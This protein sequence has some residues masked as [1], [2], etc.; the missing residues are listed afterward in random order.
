ML[1]QAQPIL[2]WT[3]RQTH[4]QGQTKAASDLLR[5]LFSAGALRQ[6]RVRFY[7]PGK[8]PGVRQAL[9]IDLDESRGAQSELDGFR[10]LWLIEQ[11]NGQVSL[12][13]SDKPPTYQSIGGTVIREQ[14]ALH[15]GSTLYG[16][17]SM[18]G[19]R[20]VRSR[21]WASHQIR[22][23][24]EAFALLRGI[25]Q[26]VLASGVE[27]FLANLNAVAL[28][29]VRTEYC[30][31]IESYNHYVSANDVANRNRVQA[32]RAFPVFAQSLRDQW[33]LRCCVDA[34]APLV[35]ELAK[36]Y[37]VRPRTI[38]GMRAL[39]QIRLPADRLTA[40]LTYV[41]QMPGEY[42]PATD[43]D[44]QA[45]LALV[46]PLTRL[47]RTLDV[48]FL[49]LARPFVNGWQQGRETL[50]RQ[51][52]GNF[53][54]TAIY[55]MMRASYRYGLYPA[56]RAKQRGSAATS[57]LSNDPPS[58]FFPLWFD[59]YSLPR[60]VEMSVKWRDA[61]R[62]FS[63]RRLGLTDP[64]LAAQ[65][66]WSGLLPAGG[67]SRDGYRVVELK[68]YQDLDQEG[69]AQRNCLAS[70]TVKCVLGE[71]AIFSIRET[72]TDKPVSTFEIGLTQNRP[73]L[74][75]H[76]GPE[77]ASPSPELKALA[78][79][80]VERVLAPLTREH[81]AAVR[82]GRRQ[83]GEQVRSILAEPNTP[84]A[85]LTPLEHARLADL[86]AFSHPKELRHRGDSPRLTLDSAQYASITAA[87]AGRPQPV[88]ARNAA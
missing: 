44:W 3:H 51:S 48:S 67:H 81:I 36:H 72:S 42:Q 35:R 38:E 2:H 85:P 28:A 4:D 37:A 15:P 1:A 43:A 64:E 34:G 58:T 46:G 41:D 56:L 23:D 21:V 32:A 25:E 87:L 65:L 68:T 71:S 9:L 83:V 55:D 33:Q 86:T 27:A 18:I 60:L 78:E 82:Q 52:G 63:M 45:F 62:R 40:A 14:P 20:R 39:T 24:A 53:D 49:Q 73:V 26:R 29:A 11:L 6:Y 70:Y 13:G 74:L 61:Y 84:R 19:A 50:D 22:I 47:A 75:Q 31:T 76:R 66:Q 12:L 5:S 7:P 16:Q 79:R 10:C 69:Q 57:S 88:L 59:R 80:F 54:V 77:N 17:L 30:F 8:A